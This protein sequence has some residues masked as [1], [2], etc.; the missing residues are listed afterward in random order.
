MLT[1][2]RPLFEIAR[3]ITADWKNVYFGAVPYI[4]AMH[5]L[6]RISDRY[7]LDSADSIVRYFLGNATAWRGETARR[8]KTELKALIN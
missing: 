2:H 6:N 8:I 3:E 7:G 4:Q 5:H 1:I